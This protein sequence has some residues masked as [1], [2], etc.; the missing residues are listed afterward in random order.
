ML[1]GTCE[2]PF[3]W[4]LGPDRGL[5]VP[6]RRDV[7]RGAVRVPDGAAAVRAGVAVEA[8]EWP[9]EAA[10]PAVGSATANSRGIPTACTGVLCN[11][12]SDRPSGR[13]ATDVCS[14]W[15]RVSVVIFSVLSN[16]SIKLA[17]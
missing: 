14:M 13:E 17:V 8:E 9:D 6:N 11:S 12:S 1:I 5:P 2:T 15:R 4:D 3:I 10:E 16:G 7:R